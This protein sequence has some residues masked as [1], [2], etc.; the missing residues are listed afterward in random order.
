M[1]SLHFWARQRNGVSPLQTK[2]KMIPKRGIEEF[3]ET[4]IIKE[5]KKR[6][7]PVGTSITKYFKSI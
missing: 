3:Y 2:P 7:P 1:M 6:I 4:K 5:G